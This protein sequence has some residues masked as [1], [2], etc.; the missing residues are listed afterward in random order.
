MFYLDGWQEPLPTQVLTM[1]ECAY[2]HALFED[3]RGG[4]RRTVEKFG[5]TSS[6]MA[7]ASSGIATTRPG[8]FATTVEKSG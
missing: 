3:D 5:A 1:A 2:L 4:V 8:R 6:W 7:A